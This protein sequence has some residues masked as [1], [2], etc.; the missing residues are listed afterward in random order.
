M[1]NDGYG[2][3]RVVSPVAG[4]P[5]EK[6]GIKSGDIVVSVDGVPL[7][8]KTLDDWGNMIRGEAG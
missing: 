4:T 5:A 1:E 3:C 8:G 2:R 7:E 6:A